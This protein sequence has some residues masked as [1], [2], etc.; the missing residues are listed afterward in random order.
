MLSLALGKLEQG[1]AKVASS[2]TSFQSRSRVN[3]ILY[4][5]PNALRILDALGV[6]A[7]IRSR[8]EEDASQGQGGSDHYHTFHKTSGWF[9]FVSGLPGHD[10][11]LDVCAWI[12]SGRALFIDYYAV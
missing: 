5:G 4:I 10:V 1:S 11:V 3:I 9:K 12:T 6:L 2:C 7:D 8:T